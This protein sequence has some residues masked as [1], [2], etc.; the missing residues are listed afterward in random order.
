MEMPKPA[1][2]HKKLGR[3]VGEWSG[4][5]T[6]H[7]SP[8]D[9]AGGT[10]RATVTNRWIVDGFAVVQEYEQRRGGKV[11]FR[12]HGVFWYD[13]AAQEYVMHWWDS[14]GGVGGAYR[15]QI[16]GER[17]TLG[18][19]M[20]QGGHARTSWTQTGPNTHTFL[21]EVSQDGKTWHPSM[22]GRYKRGGAKKSAP[23]KRAAKKSRSKR[24]AKKRVAK[25]KAAKKRKS[26]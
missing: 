4:E 15:G 17:L 11:T 8:W 1:D 12:G 3:L 2:V 13:P 9:P 18:A 26:R 10:A 21:M 20:P 6:L 23:A 19:P 16:E 14:M 24:A 5:E 7:P 22:E 25:A